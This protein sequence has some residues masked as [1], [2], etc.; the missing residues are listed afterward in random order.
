MVDYTSEKLKHVAIGTVIVVAALALLGT[1]IMSGVSS[2]GLDI[3]ESSIKKGST[4]QAIFSMTVKNVG[5]SPITNIK[6]SIADLPNGEFSFDVLAGQLNVG[7]IV[8]FTESLP[9]SSTLP[10]GTSY[11][12]IVNATTAAGNTIVE[13]G[14]VYVTRI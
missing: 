11:P 2:E 1:G 10:A 13:T 4:T 7:G 9:N 14:I 6:G 12:V 5:N 3:N 8:S